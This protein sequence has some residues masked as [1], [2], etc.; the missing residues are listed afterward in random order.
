MVSFGCMV[1]LSILYI[2]S[3]SLYK[4][5]ERFICINLII[6]LI[7]LLLVV[8]FCVGIDNR[9]DKIKFKK[10]CGETKATIYEIETKEKVIKD[11]DGKEKKEVKYI[12]HF[13]YS[14]MNTDDY[15]GSYTDFHKL[16]NEGDEITIYYNKENPKDYR[17]SISYLSLKFLISILILVSGLKIFEFLRVKKYEANEDL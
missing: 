10:Q 9:I 16:H 12:Y 7:E 15:R 6:A 1:F 5:N 2:I 8:F 3:M 17:L 13:S 11:N 14:A 4:G